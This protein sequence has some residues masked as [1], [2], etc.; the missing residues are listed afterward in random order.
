MH[1]PECKALVPELW[2][3]GHKK[4][5]ADSKVNRAFVISF[6]FGTRVSR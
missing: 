6:Q 1:D 2:R 3:V 5:S 4:W